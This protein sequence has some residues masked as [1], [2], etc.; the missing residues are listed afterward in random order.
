MS[1]LTSEGIRQAAIQETNWNYF[2]AGL[3]IGAVG[4]LLTVLLVVVL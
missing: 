1:L 3:S 4:S 2:A